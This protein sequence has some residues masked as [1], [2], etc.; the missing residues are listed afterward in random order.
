MDGVIIDS[1]P[2]HHRAERALL[3][4]YQVTITDEEL[5]S[6]AGMDAYQLLTGFIEK[7]KLPVD[8]QTFYLMHKEN[9]EKVFRNSDIPA[10]AAVHFIREVDAR[11]LPLALAS[12]SHRDLIQLVM[13]RLDLSE[14]FH[15]II[16]GD[17]I[18]RGKPFPDI[19]IKA[20]GRLKLS[21]EQCVAIEDSKNGVHSAKDAGCFCIGVV[22][23]NSGH[24]DLSRAD[25]IIDNFRRLNVDSVIEWMTE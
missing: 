23:P 11:A 2:L 9:I 19:Y 13:E 1:E 3:S 22:N 12:S 8:F 10:T 6:F 7:Y 5:H 18:Q 24:Q 17:E 15:V 14:Y 4:R 20:A 21:P 16:G 25:K